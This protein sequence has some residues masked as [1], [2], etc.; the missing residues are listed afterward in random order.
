MK[1]IV[2]MERPTTYV[3]IIQQM[4]VSDVHYHDI[5]HSFIE[6]YLLKSSFQ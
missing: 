5:D 4:R 1:H 3:H 2:S 6:A